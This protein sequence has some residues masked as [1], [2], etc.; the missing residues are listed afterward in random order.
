MTETT[1]EVR[2]IVFQEEDAWVA[3]VLEHDICTQS[4]SYET[5]LEELPTIIS[6]HAILSIENGMEPLEDIPPAPRNFLDLW[7]EKRQ[8]ATSTRSKVPFKANDREFGLE[9]EV[10]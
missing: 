7:N 2:V 10:A 3:Q 9:L 1:I 8:A 5:L 4:D 6:A